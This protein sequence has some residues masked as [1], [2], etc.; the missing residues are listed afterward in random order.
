MAKRQF[1]LLTSISSNE[2]SLCSKYNSGANKQTEFE[3]VKNQEGTKDSNM[4]EVLQKFIDMCGE[5]QEPCCAFHDFLNYWLEYDIDNTYYNLLSDALR[6]GISEIQHLDKPKEEKEPMFVDL[7]NMFLDEF[8][9][10]P[11]TKT[12]DG[13]YEVSLST[14]SHIQDVV[15]NPQNETDVITKEKT[16]KMEKQNMFEQAI[17]LLKSA[18]GL[19]KTE[20]PAEEQPE[21]QP[22]VEEVA[23]ETQEVEAPATEETVEE[24]PVEEVAKTEEVEPAEVE[25]PVVEESV[26]EKVEAEEVIANEGEENGLQEQK[27]EVEQEEAKTEEVIEEVAKTESET[28]A[29]NVEELVK[30]KLEVEKELAELKKANEIKAIEIE[31]MTFV[32]KAKDEYSM[33]VGTPE[34][35]GEKLYSI[36][37]SSLSE[38]VKDFV[39]EQL[40][41]VSASNEELTEEVGS[42]TKN[43]GD[44]TDEEI[45]YAKAEE[46]AKAEGISI[47]KALRKINK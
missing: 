7:F 29:V 8:R 16:S 30:A 15:E 41:K 43:A 46:L 34:E 25:A 24:T 35:I 42:I 32:Q 36:S 37:K 19:E 9:A 20:T 4:K 12:Q 38:D 33:L 47:N 6:N 28:E 44:M 13:K 17:D 2:V 27:E 21:V 31:K 18:F 40:K 1:R 3:L 39:M 22:Q 26:E 23:E 11:I 14:N 5:Q 10:L 45:V